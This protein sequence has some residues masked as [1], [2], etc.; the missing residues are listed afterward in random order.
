MEPRDC[1]A[2]QDVPVAILQKRILSAKS[3]EDKRKLEKKMDELMQSRELVRDVMHQIVEKSTDSAE[4]AH[5]VMNSKSSAYTSKPYKDVVEYFRA[6]SFDWHDP[7]YQTTLQHLYLFS[8]LLGE[9]VPVERI[10]AAIDEVTATLKE[11]KA[12]VAVATQAK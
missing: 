12:D 11:E 8:N 5:R 10:K 6:K 4:H 9:K 2:N 1:V 7:K 3:P